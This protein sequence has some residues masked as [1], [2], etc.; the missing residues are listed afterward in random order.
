MSWKLSSV[1]MAGFLG[2]GFWGGRAPAALGAAPKDAL[3]NAGWSRYLAGIS[4]RQGPDALSAMKSARRRATAAASP[5]DYLLN[6]DSVRVTD[7]DGDGEV[8]VG[9]QIVAD[10]TLIDPFNRVA[11]IFEFSEA[12]TRDG[13]VGT[14][15]LAFPGRGSLVVGGGTAYSD[16]TR[17]RTPVRS[18]LG[19]TGS[20]LKSTGQVGYVT[21][22]KDLFVVLGVR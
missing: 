16:G 20:F 21:D 14:I 4:R 19:G 5:I 9:D 18:I 17:S 13:S 7:L 6:V 12:F 8:T 11:G 1:V 3:S 22:G 2:F 10:G 15:Q